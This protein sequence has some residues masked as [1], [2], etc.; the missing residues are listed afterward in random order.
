MGSAFDAGHK[1]RGGFFLAPHVVVSPAGD[2][3]TPFD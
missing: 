3:D 2:E 1:P